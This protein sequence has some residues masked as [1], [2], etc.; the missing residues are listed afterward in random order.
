MAPLV[1]NQIVSVDNSFLNVETSQSFYDLVFVYLYWIDIEK[2]LWLVYLSDVDG[3]LV[4]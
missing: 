2:I 4:L 3:L 1:D